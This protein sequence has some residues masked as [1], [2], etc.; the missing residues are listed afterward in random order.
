[1]T[2]EQEHKAVRTIFTRPAYAASAAAASYLAAA[3][4][5]TAAAA[6]AFSTKCARSERATP[7]LVGD[8]LVSVDD[9]IVLGLD[10]DT[11]LDVSAVRPLCDA[12]PTYA[13]PR[14]PHARRTWHRPSARPLPRRRSR[15]R[16]AT[17]SASSSSAAPR[18]VGGSHV[19]TSWWHLGQPRR[20]AHPPTLL[21]ADLPVRADQAR[22]GLVPE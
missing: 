22:R 20:P 8:Q 13:P 15:P 3:T 12:S 21:A 6:S 2:P 4:V 1:M 9:S 7:V 18:S 10:F 19:P 5:A 16:P 17:P 14:A 11:A